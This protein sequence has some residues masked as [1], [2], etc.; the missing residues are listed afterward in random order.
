MHQLYHGCEWSL[1]LGRTAEAEE[2]AR[3]ALRLASAIHDRQLTVYLLALLAATTAAHGELEKAG[4]V[5]GAVEAD[6]ARGLIGQWEAERDAYA[7][8]VLEYENDAFER[9]RVEG[10]RMKLPDAV[11]YALS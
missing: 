1:E 9:G 5:W 2:Y 11:E 6:E 4:V 8:R 3:D 10:R 7:A